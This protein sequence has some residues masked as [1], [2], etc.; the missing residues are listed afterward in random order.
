M[1]HS[2]ALD[3]IN[4][5]EADYPVASYNYLGVPLWPIIRTN[6]GFELIRGDVIA[7]APA[8]PNTKTRTS[9]GS[10]RNIVTA[11]F[12]DHKTRFI[13]HRPRD[14]AFLGN[15]FSRIKLDNTYYDRICD[16]LAETYLQ[17]GYSTAHFEPLRGFD[18]F[19]R[20]NPSTLI[21]DEVFRY[22]KTL[23]GIENIARYPISIYQEL[24]PIYEKIESKTGKETHFNEYRAIRVALQVAEFTAVWTAV[25]RRLKPKVVFTVL[26]YNQYGWSLCLACKRLGIPSIEL[27]HGRQDETHH[28]YAR[29]RQVPENG[30][31]SLPK[32][33]WTWSQREAA[34][35]D[36]WTTNQPKRPHQSFIGG[37]PFLDMCRNDPPFAKAHQTALKTLR[38][39]KAG[40]PIILATPEYSCFCVEPVIATIEKSPKHWHWLLRMHPLE[41]DRIDELKELLANRG[42]SNAEIELPTQAPLYLVLKHADLHYTGFSSTIL[43]AKQFE[44]RS[45]S[46]SPH[47]ME[48]FQSEIKSGWLEVETKIESCID[49][50][51][52][53]LK[54]K[55]PKATEPVSNTNTIKQTINCL[56]RQLALDPISR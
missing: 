7:N 41:T 47:A 2:E 8:V 33:F 13:A 14:V 55:R 22:A 18:R 35:I 48:I 34:T 36:A 3:L 50:I 5:I 17:Y 11:S 53:A 52:R 29:W 24:R 56:H 54:S 19:P 27:P 42:I 40:T 12:L 45:V 4:E 15:F 25:L 38:D 43:E 28:A 39:E 32:I 10:L 23:Y 20:R 37:N 46:F 51:D 26:Y 1:N 16:P 30:Y 44:V 6:L 9:P 31:D 49:L 21:S